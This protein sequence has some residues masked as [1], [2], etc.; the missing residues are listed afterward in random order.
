[1]VQSR[2]AV[3]FPGQGS[4][5]RSTFARADVQR[6]FRQVVEEI[7]SPADECR[8][9]AQ[10]PQAGGALPNYLP[11]A[12]HSLAISIFTASVA[13]YRLLEDQGLHPVV[14]IGH[15]FG[16]IIAL[17][18]AG[19][20]SA[21]QGAEIVFQR[22]AVLNGYS[23]E[24]G[25][26]LVAR[27]TKALAD[28]LVD[29]AGSENAAVAAENSPTEV[30]ISGTAAGIERIERFARYLGIVVTR[31]RARWPLHCRAVMVLAA[32]ELKKRLSHIS[33]Q[34]LRVPVFSPILGRCYGDA[35]N[36]TE[37]LSDE[38][39]LPVRFADAIRYLLSTGAEAFI[40]CGPLYGLG[41]CVQEI[42]GGNQ[43][44][45]ESTRFESPCFSQA[46]ARPS[47]DT[48]GGQQEPRHAAI[49]A[50]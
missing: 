1:M 26:M 7:G 35:D 48:H 42:A 28:T 44:S 46:T 17:V 40:E 33:S 23:T 19:A 36:L 41:R 50:N 5:S 6:Y 8:P 43:L 30:V 15:G 4:L 2:T 18:C 38:L 31:L 21:A 49:L 12:P 37:M 16:E 39:A 22:A 45:L 24:A 27:T 47:R 34:P 29:L 10:S 25:G 32:T 3:L 11:D 14:M 20:L 13:Q 9:W